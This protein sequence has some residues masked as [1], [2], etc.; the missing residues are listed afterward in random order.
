[1][2][3]S[4]AIC[5]LL[6]AAT[7]LT[8]C[9]IVEPRWLSDNNAFLKEFSERDMLPVLGVVLAI[10]LASAA[11]LH[12]EFNKVEE[13][14]RKVFLNRSRS[15]VHEAAYGLIAAFLIAAL[16][17]IVKAILP[18][19]E[20]AQAIVNAFD[21]MILVFNILILIEITQVAFAIPPKID[22]DQ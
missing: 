13:R 11:Q 15:G 3:K 18:D 1:M 2:T 21:I 19:Y 5:A 14:A 12:L 6:S 8:I 20:R 7:V 17:C 4:I 16:L 22:E 9:V 10:T